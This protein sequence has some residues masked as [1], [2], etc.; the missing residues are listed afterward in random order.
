MLKPLRVLLVEDLEDDALLIVRTLRKGGFE[1][2]Y[3]RV[4]TAE[5][6][7]FALLNAAWDIILCDY[8][9]PGFS[10]LDAILLLKKMNL[11]IPLIIVSGAI[12]EETALDCIHRGASDYIMKG[13]PARL[14]LSV[15]R[16][17]EKKVL[18]ARQKSDEE[19]LRRSEEKFKTIANY[20]VDWESWFGPD[21][22]YLWVNPAVERIT[23]YTPE[24]VLAMPDFISVM[25]FEEDRE[26]FIRHFQTALTGTRGN[27]FEIRCVRKD[28]THF[29][30]SVS[31]QPVYDEQGGFLGIRTSGRDIT[32]VK[33]AEEERF[34]LEKQLFNSQKME[35][36]GAL[37]GGIAHDFN[38]ML[39]AMMGYAELALEPSAE[40]RRRQNIQQVLNAA[41][42]AGNL[43]RQILSFSR[44]AELDKKPLELQSIVREAMKLLRATIPSNIDIRQQL[45]DKPMV[46]LADDTQMHQVI[47]NLCTNAAQA[48]GER[49]GRIDITLRA[50]EHSADPCT[51]N[52]KSEKCARI[53]ISDSGPGISPDIINRIFDPFFTTKKT[54][55]GT[56]L[57]LSVVY[58][59]IKNHD[60]SIR[61]ESEPGRGTTFD[62]WLPL[63]DSMHQASSRPSP[64]AS[65]VETGS[66]H[67]L[68][69]DDEEDLAFLMQSALS[70]LGYR[71]T[72]CTSSPEALNL[73][74]A[75]PAA[76]DLVITDMTMPH[77]SGSELAQEI[78]KRKPT[79]PVI[80]CS[81]YSSFMD[82]DKAAA[83]GIRA[84]LL[85]PLSRRELA[86]AVRKVLDDPA[87]G[88]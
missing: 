74:L 41:R 33:K 43:V 29:W 52:S 51:G 36:I 5:E 67:I 58:G 3:E 63:A 35:A 54:G 47:M 48:M 69:V 10:G 86:A 72:A 71:V 50:E 65:A 32:S 85:K 7:T 46:V 19:A 9:M 24:E 84:F 8:H 31:W 39:S 25:V 22:K 81:G 75:D 14:G 40:D 30:L 59:I 60:G 38:N 1:P 61:V 37:A 88:G 56:G 57:G 79:Q 70:A 6:M 66:E 82:A 55:E 2:A 27:N 73:F 53:I 26:S 68:V 83:I 18:R 87:A 21:G 49:G 12:G 13:N 28:K 77:L 42:R 4:Q 20:T 17:L 62:V 64:A 78:L 34:H 44:H 45:P 80:L 15:Q 76:F 11:D 23:G 16:E